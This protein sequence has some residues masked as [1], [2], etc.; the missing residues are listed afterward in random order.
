LVQVELTNIS[1]AFQFFDSQNARG[2]DLEPHDLLKAFHL[3]E[4]ADS[5]TESE[6]FQTVNNWEN[7]D[8]QELK[9]IFSRYLYRIRNWS[10]GYSARKFTKREVGIF[11]GVSPSIEEPY[12][13]ANLSRIGHFYIDAY[14]KEY[15]RN[16]D[17]NT[18]DF[19]FQ[20]DQIIINGKRF[21]EMI[22]HYVSIMDKIK[23]L[24]LHSENS[25]KIMEVLD[26]YPGKKRRGDGYVRNLFDCC[27]LY[28]WDKFGSVDID[29]AIEVYFIWAYSLRL[30]QHSVQLASTDKHALKSPFVFKKIKEAI[31][32]SEAFNIEI[33]LLKS[34]ELK[35]SRS[36]VEKII[37]LFI[38]LKY[39]NE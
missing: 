21:F 16:I 17:N 8:I 34:T 26:D 6:K 19:P 22:E 32:P 9:I 25:K 2:K 23:K 1:E 29:R 35:G 30:R 12:P 38:Q 24:E 7:Q 27:I 14:N 39:Y 33:P 31:K 28:Y 13:F 10:R 11:K 4:L 36:K 37:G 15:H 18:M 5:T 20:I 3:R